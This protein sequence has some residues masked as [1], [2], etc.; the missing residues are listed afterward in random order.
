MNGTQEL[1]Q[2]KLKKNKNTEAGNFDLYV[3][4]KISFYRTKNPE[5]ES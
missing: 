5:I 3:K 2:Q 4:Y 1:E